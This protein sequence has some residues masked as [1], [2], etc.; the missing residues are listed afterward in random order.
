MDI[1]KLDKNFAVNGVTEEIRKETEFFNA[2]E[3]PFKIYGLTLGISDRLPK[4][5]E[6]TDELR[7]LSVCT[8]GGRIRFKTDSDYIVI[9]A[10]IP[11]VN[12][13]AHMT[14]T[15]SY[16]FDIYEKEKE[17]YKFLGAFQPPAGTDASKKTE[18]SGGYE[19]YLN[20]GSKKIRDLTI[21]MPLYNPVSKVWIGVRKGSKLQKGSEYTYKKPIVYYGSSITQGG[22]ASRPGNSYQAML[23]RMYDADHIN[24]GFS[25]N[26]KG[27]KNV[28]EYLAELEMSI[29]VLDY[30]HNAPT[31][32]H[33]EAT[34]ERMFKI[35]REKNPK[36]PII[37]ATR[38]KLVLNDEEKQ[39]FKIIKKTY[40]NAKKNGDENVYFV[41]GTK[42]FKNRGDDS[43]TV[44]NSHPTDLGF[45]AM[46]QE[47]NKIFKKLL[48]SPF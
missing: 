11:C 38:P 47:F 26:A 8:A 6:I 4:D 31:P 25:G 19:S 1:K 10:E 20:F 15:G 43:C 14:I 23:T 9:R 17:G 3:K 5:L 48:T 29:F 24:M 34:H 22:C 33:L 42:M 39:R 45:W 16:G 35:I 7:G 12:H 41:D 13:M 32:E 44:D 28:A 40:T 21:N 36:I 2:E 27:E 30:D 46:T 18:T 37:M